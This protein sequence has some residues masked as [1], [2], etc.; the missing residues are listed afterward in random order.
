MLHRRVGRIFMGFM[1][2]PLRGYT[3]H[4]CTHCGGALGTHIDRTSVV[5]RQVLGRVSVGMNGYCNNS[6]C[7]ALSLAMKI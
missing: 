3:S 1:V 5:D 4:I 2:S 6:L 7:W